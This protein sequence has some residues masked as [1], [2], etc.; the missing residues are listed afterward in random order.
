VE[1]DYQSGSGHH[2]FLFHGPCIVK[3]LTCGCKEKS[4][5]IPE[6]TGDRRFGTLCVRHLL[7]LCEAY[8]SGAATGA[9]YME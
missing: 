2:W 5:I 1:I 8:T 3:P 7:A 9:T 6:G 4:D